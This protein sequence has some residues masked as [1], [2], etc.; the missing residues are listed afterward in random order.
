MICGHEYA[1]KHIE[2]IC[3]L[4]F[5]TIIVDECH[6]VKNPDAEIT[7]AFNQFVC[8]RRFGLTGT[9]IQNRYQELYTILDCELGVT[10]PG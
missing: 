6:K 4:D 7:K 10:I 1:R 2:D 5:S 9:A 3:D 8:Q